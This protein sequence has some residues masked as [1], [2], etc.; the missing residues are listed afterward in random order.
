MLT[1]SGCE[2]IDSTLLL[3]PQR[4][5]GS[6]QDVQHVVIL[7]QEN[8]SFDHYFGSCSGVRG[9]GDR[10]TVPLPGGKPI[11][12]QNDGERDFAPFHLDTRTTSALRVAGTPHGWLDAQRAWNQGRFGLW[13]KWKLAH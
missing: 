13:P 8:R 9:F 1:A 7:M 4:L 5:T 2:T 12:Y 10:I 6:I 11:W 3:S